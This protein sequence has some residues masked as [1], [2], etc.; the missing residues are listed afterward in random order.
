MSTEYTSY[1][2]SKPPY[3]T[4]ET[5]RFW[6]ATAEGR[7]ELAVCDSCGFIPF[8]PR[9][10]CPD[11]QSTSM[12]WRTMSGEGTVYSFSVT[13]AGGGRAWK[14]HLPF[15]VAYVEL[16]EGPIMMTNIVDCDPEGV[17]VGM[18]VRAVFDD[19]GEGTSLVRFTPTN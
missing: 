16:A 7:I 2:P 3:P 1:L 18:A 19:T 11:C 9:S 13:R 17:T 12:T 4:P 14:E 5:R 6:D 8:Y 10:I 15:V